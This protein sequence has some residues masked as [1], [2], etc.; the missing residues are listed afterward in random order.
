MYK[1][2]LTVFPVLILS[3]LLFSE[4]GYAAVT[5]ESL[6]NRLDDFRGFRDRGFTFDITNISY[7][8]EKEPRTNKLSVKVFNEQSLIQ[9][10]APAREKGRAMLRENANMWLYIPG[11][12]RVIRI[13]PS[14]RLI[15]ETSNGD[16]VGANFSKDYKAEL[17]GQE[18]V[19]GEIYWILQLSA[20]TSGVAYEKVNVWMSQSADNR[21]FKAE[22]YTR[23]GRLL[24][25][26]YYKEFKHYEGELKLHKLLLVDALVEDSHT[27]M[28]FDDY[29]F[30]NLDPAIFQK[31]SLGRLN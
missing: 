15:G 25:T 22:F 20:S 28:K 5:A 8:K 1:L 9:F 29:R 6:V 7:K 2:N 4:L 26:A 11:T 13:A 21:P 24:K 14:Q 10:M 19:E 27:W 23:S 30:E 3:C 18:I 31:G 16:V 12:R 17:K